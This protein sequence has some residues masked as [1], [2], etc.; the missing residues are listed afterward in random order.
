MPSYLWKKPDSAQEETEQN[1][2]KHLVNMWYWKSTLRGAWRV[3]EMRNSVGD[4]TGALLSPTEFAQLSTLSSFQSHGV[5]PGA[6]TFTVTHQQSDS[7]DRVTGYSHFYL[8]CV[9]AYFKQS[10]VR[11]FQYAFMNVFVVARAR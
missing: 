1:K 11:K 2:T 10:L 8:W 3:P 6:R 9:G 7:E 4:H 5:L